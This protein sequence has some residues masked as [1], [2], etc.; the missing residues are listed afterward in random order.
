MIDDRHMDHGLWTEEGRRG[1]GG[2]RTAIARWIGSRAARELHPGVAGRV[3]A[4]F[5]RA[6]DLVTD[7]GTVIAVGWDST[8]RGPLTITLDGPDGGALA[9]Q[10]RSARFRI[11]EGQLLLRSQDSLQARIDLSEAVTWEAKLRWE[12]LRSRWRQVLGATP[13]VTRAAIQTSML[14]AASRWEG[15]L[16]QAAAA[17]TVAYLQGD[18]DGLR[19]AIGALCGL[20]EGLTPQGDDWLMGW[21]L[22]LHLVGPANPDDRS[23]EELGADVLAAASDRSPVLSRALLRCAVAGEA[24]ESWHVLLD[25]MAEDAADEQRI[26]RAT[27]SVLAHGATSGAAMLRGFLAGLGLHRES[28]TSPV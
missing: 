25:E 11:T 24:P 19:S 4:S 7:D 26:E 23:V 9:W 5:A 27:R 14:G 21:L 2:E 6:T 18:R 16:S 17:V 8:E 28:Q 10:P 1:N 20:G 15:P 13:V 3:L 22:A 12:A